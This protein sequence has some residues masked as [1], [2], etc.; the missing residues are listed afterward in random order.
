MRN[1]KE[2]KMCGKGASNQ[3]ESHEKKGDATSDSTTNKQYKKQP[4][5]RENLFYLLLLLTSLWALLRSPGLKEDN[6]TILPKQIQD[7]RHYM[8]REQ[9]AVY[10]ISD[11]CLSTLSIL[12]FVDIIYLG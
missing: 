12:L 11:I 1:E 2:R 7:C 10:L 6:T 5:S 4:N 8:P 3:F 9:A